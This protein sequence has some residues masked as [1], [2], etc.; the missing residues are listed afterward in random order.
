MQLIIFLCDNSPIPLSGLEIQASRPGID[1]PTVTRQINMSNSIVSQCSAQQSPFDSIR[2]YRADGVEYW[3]ARELMK[4]LGYTRWEQGEKALNRAMKSMGNQ[5][6]DVTSQVHE[7]L[8]LSNQHNGKVVEI[9]D[10]ELS[11]FACYTVAMN[12][13]PEKEMVALAQGY[14][15]NQTRKAELSQLPTELSRLEIL[16][17]ALASENEKLLLEAQIEADRPATELGKAIGKS[18]S[19]IRIGDFAKAIGMG[20]NRY[21]KELR[22]CEIIMATSTLPYQRFLNSGY[23]V[24]TQVVQGDRIFPVSL[25]TPK[26]QAYL[27]RRHQ[28]HLDSVRVEFQIESAIEGALV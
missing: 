25:I 12:A 21:F 27:A 28:Q 9:R 8:K 19:N 15:A 17:L 2:G 14:F 10:F 16:Q 23:F 6:H 18:A 1:P 13:D 22:E 3:T 24:V 26:G 5:G 11:R 20:Q 4:W 7:V